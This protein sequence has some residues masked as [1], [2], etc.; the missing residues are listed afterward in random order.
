MT[1][2]I[3]VGGGMRGTYGAGVLDCFLD[4]GIEFDYCIGV[5]AGS[6]NLASFLAKQ[7]ERGLRFYT[8][9]AADKRFMGLQSFFAT[10]SFFGLDFIYETLTNEIDPID[11]DTLLA[12]KSKL[13]VVATKANDGRP[14]YFTNKDFQR[15]NSEVLKAS[16]AIPIVCSPVEIK[17][18]LYFDGGVSD[19]IPV[20]KAL[21]DGCDKL[22]V[23]LTKPIDFVMGRERTSLL[24]PYLLKKYPAIV[25]ALDHR[26][27]R[28][29]RAIRLLRKLEK[30]GRAVIIA[31]SQNYKI[32]TG[33]NDPKILRGFYN[34][35]YDD[36]MQK[37]EGIVKQILTPNQQ[38]ANDLG[39]APV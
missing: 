23:I 2:L 26:R 14:H 4:Y 21:D 25:K 22:V 30:E 31:P 11:Y 10:K 32:S 13:N 33:T 7:R 37:L 17:G 16:C 24:H 36:T 20:K 39:V 3:D 35:G 15:N 18:Q 27:I 38:C 9:H 1:G 29:R 6:G 19:P 34:L 5:S 28:Y 12:S 8:V